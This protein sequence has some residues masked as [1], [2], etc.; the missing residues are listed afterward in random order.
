MLSTRIVEL[1]HAS[2]RAIELEHHLQTETLNHKATR[3]ALF[4]EK[5]R[6][7][8]AIRELQHLH[9]IQK[10]SD[11]LLRALRETN[12]DSDKPSLTNLVDQAMQEARKESDETAMDRIE[13]NRLWQEKQLRLQHYAAALDAR[14]RA[15]EQREKLSYAPPSFLAGLVGFQGQRR[16]L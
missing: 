3:E 9:N 14:E 6:L 5:R 12:N 2:A 16:E 10:G 11:R 1:E 15:L 8:D 13:R 7:E 4:D